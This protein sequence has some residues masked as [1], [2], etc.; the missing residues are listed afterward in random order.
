MKE[1]VEAILSLSQEIP[2]F[3]KQFTVSMNGF[4]KI[5]NVTEFQAIDD[6]TIPLKLIKLTVTS[7]GI[8]PTSLVLSLGPVE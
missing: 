8:T 3:K 7:R 4:S 1:I 2:C 5:L 6:G